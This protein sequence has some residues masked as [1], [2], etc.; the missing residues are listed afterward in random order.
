MCYSNETVSWKLYG[1]LSYHN[2]C[3]QREQPTVYTSL[4]EQLLYWITNTIGNNLMI[5]NL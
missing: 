3:G 4:S 5:K 2:N 1:M